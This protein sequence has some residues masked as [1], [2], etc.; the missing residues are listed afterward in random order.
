MNNIVERAQKLWLIVIEDPDQAGEAT[1][2]FL[3]T[4]RRLALEEAAQLMEETDYYGNIHPIDAKRIRA[5]GEK[6]D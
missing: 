3:R 4:E 6:D 1:L 2:R 5:L